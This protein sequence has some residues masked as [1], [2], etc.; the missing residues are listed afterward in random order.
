MQSSKAKCAYQLRNSGLLPPALTQP[1]LLIDAT[2]NGVISALSFQRDFWKDL[3]A[4]GR[5]VDVN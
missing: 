3:L 1:G 4:T 2:F 5:R